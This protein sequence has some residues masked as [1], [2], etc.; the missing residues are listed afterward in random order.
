[1]HSHTGQLYEDYILDGALAEKLAALR[2]TRPEEQVGPLLKLLRKFPDPTSSAVGL[3]IA[4]R[5]S[6]RFDLPLTEDFD[7]PASAIPKLITRFWNDPKPLADVERLM[8]SWNECEPC[9]R[10]ETFN[11]ATALNYLRARCAPQIADAFGRTGEPAQRADLFRLARLHV[12]GGF[13]I[14]ADDAHGAGFRRMFRRGSRFSR[15][16]RTLAPSA[17]MSSARRRVIRRSNWRWAR[18]PPRFCAAIAISCG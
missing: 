11:D 18:L 7:R 9:F 14:D 15:I 17:T 2:G 16:R 8:A 5:R 13:Y 10:I 3:M 4:L 12:E 1:M 6:G